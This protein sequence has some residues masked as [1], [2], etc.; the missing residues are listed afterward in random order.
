MIPEKNCIVKSNSASSTQKVNI[1]IVDDHPENLLA[2]EAVLMSPNYHFIRANSGEEALMYVLKQDFAVIVLDVQMPGLNGFETAQLIKEREKSKHIPIIFVT[3]ISKDMENILCGYSVGAIDYI[4]KPFHPETL[5]RKI[6]QLVKIYENHEQSEW[7]RALELEEVNKK[8]DRTTLDLRN[9]EALERVI[10]ET[11]ADTIVTFDESGYIFSVN[12]AV[13]G[14]FGYSTE[15][16]L[17]Q[18][19]TN[20]LPALKQDEGKEAPLIIAPSIKPITGRLMEAVALRKDKSHF[21][22]DIQ[23]GEAIIENQNIYVC[24]IRDI[25][26]RKKFEAL[27]RQQ[28]NNLEKLVEERTLELLLANEKLQNEIKERKKI[29]DDLHVSHERFRKIFESS[30]CLIAIRSLKDGRFIDVND[31]WLHYTGYHYEEVTNQT[32]DLLHLVSDSGNSS[33]GIFSLEHAKSIRNEKIR[34]QSKSKEVREGLLSTELI[35]IQGESCILIVVTDITERI[36]LEKEMVRLDRLNLIG[37]MAAGIAHEIRNPLTTVR[38]FL[39]IS[40]TNHDYLTLEHI[41]LML[42]ELD[43]ANSIITEFLNLAKNKVNDKTNQHLNVILNAL[44][45]LIQAEALLSD[46][47]VLLEL[48]E[49][50]ELYL[51]EKEIRQLVLNLVLNGLEAMSSRGMLTIKTYSEEQSV[52]LE[53]RDQGMGIKPEILEKIGTPFFTTKDKGSGLG[54]AI[55]YSVAERHHAIIDVKSSDQGTAFSIRFKYGVPFGEG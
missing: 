21:P 38:G 11:L 37:E 5:R 16:L 18:H 25:T 2:L 19:V 26:D 20:L 23:I 4:S 34:Y 35:E 33:V 15:E 7:E 1:L 10:G 32:A 44:F 27:R 22:A 43:R 24:S 52:V 40:K 13:K 53:I 9:K 50:P 54:L 8:L 39:Q 45:P 48:G 6:E 12:P 55:C 51:D 41:D 30:P 17:D 46:K 49:C 31:S 28:F 36:Q 47:H 14:M 3:A 42:I 29:A